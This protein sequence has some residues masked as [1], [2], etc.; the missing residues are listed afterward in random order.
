MNQIGIRARQRRQE[1]GITQR[2]LAEAVGVTKNF[3]TI[4]EAGYKNPSVYTLNQIASELGVTLDYLV[5]GNEKKT[6]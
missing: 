1:L 6:N 4:F 2:E 5:N 3:I